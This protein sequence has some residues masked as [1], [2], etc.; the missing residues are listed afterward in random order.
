MP[1]LYKFD[2]FEQAYLTSLSTQYCVVVA[3]CGGVLW[4]RVVCGGV[5]WRVVGACGGGGVWWWWRVMVP[6]S[7]RSN[8]SLLRPR[9]KENKKKLAQFEPESSACR[10]A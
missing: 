8:Q 10:S 6:K 4:W 5:W 1:I 7:L 9:Q 2:V 3:C